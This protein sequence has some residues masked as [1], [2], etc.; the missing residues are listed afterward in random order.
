MAFLS[1]HTRAARRAFLLAPLLLIRLLTAQTDAPATR[2]ALF[3]KASSSNNV[4][5]LLGSVH[6]GTKSMYPLPPEIEDAFARSTALAVEIDISRVDMQKMQGVILKLGIYPDG[7][8]LWKHITP[9]TRRLLDQFC[10]TYGLDPERFV[11]TKPWL[12]SMSI[13]MVPLLKNGMDPGMGIDKYFMDKSNGKRIVEIESAEEQFQMFASFPDDVQDKILANALKDPGDAQSKAKRMETAWM[14]GD[15]AE[16]ERI[17]IT[18]ASGPPEVQRAILHDRNPRMADAAEKLLKSKEVGFVMVGAAHL[19]GK[20][21][22]VA[23]LQSRGYQVEQV[24]L[25]K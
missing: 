10:A 19:V 7:D 6:L 8:T 18:N 17:A 23:I 22:V 14:A 20:D 16:I 13:A 5:Y 12:V 24:T 15:P 11:V 4:V 9:E 25:R 2:K 3:W 1:Y 21:G